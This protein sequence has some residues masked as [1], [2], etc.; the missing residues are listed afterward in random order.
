MKRVLFAI[1]LF[2]PVLAMSSQVDALPE[3]GTIAPIAWPFST[4]EAL[5]QP[6]GC[7]PNPG[8]VHVEQYQGK[9]P[10]GTMRTWS[11]VMSNNGMPI[12][13][14]NSNS[15]QTVISNAGSMTDSNTGA[16]LVSANVPVPNSFN[17][18]LLTFAF[19]KDIDN[20]QGVFG[21][22]SNPVDSSKSRTDD[23]AKVTGDPLLQITYGNLV[24]TEINNVVACFNNDGS[25]LFV[26]AGG[27]AINDY[28]DLT[29][30]QSAK[31]SLVD[32]TTEIQSEVPQL[33]FNANG[34]L[35]GGM[36]AEGSGLAIRNAKFSNLVPGTVY[37]LTLTLSGPGKKD[38]VGTMRFL[39][40]DGC[41]VGDIR[42][43][44]NPSPYGF[45]AIDADG[46][47]LYPF[48]TVAVKN[49]VK[50]LIGIRV[51][52][53]YV[54]ATKSMPMINRS[55]AGWPDMWKY[56]PEFDDWA[57]TV[58]GQVVITRQT[59]ISA[60]AYARCAPSSLNVTVAA[61][62]EAEAHAKQFCIVENN[63]VIPTGE[64]PCLLKVT[65][66]RVIVTKSG[67]RKMSAPT[68]L[69]VPFTIGSFDAAAAG[70]AGRMRACAFS[71]TTKSSPSVAKKVVPCSKLKVGKGQTTTVTVQSE[72]KS[73]CQLKAGLV[74]R[75][76]SGTCLL[77]VV[78]KKAKKTVSQQLVGV[79]VS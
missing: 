41:P 62:T 54:T 72:S 50:D 10:I 33:G 74:K 49:W 31:Y 59:I 7:T 60:T 77:K 1:C 28:I 44:T 75:K 48:A 12:Q 5:C 70:A 43:L 21:L 9:M 19:P 71:V 35:R 40:P 68:T 53:L 79:S 67:V 64:G 8:Y 38:I 29:G 15:C 27:N 55:E 46:K 78:V 39:T 3:A 63:Q 42:D 32:G 25:G 14:C 37:S 56:I 34:E 17:G 26:R 76:S 73:V 2:V 52:P 65:V 57:K 13:I 22:K 6:A 24:A 66:S 58:D 11:Q 4:P 30:Y 61:L 20:P 23:N 45:A 16:Y 69:K 51:A 47:F 36:C 18:Q